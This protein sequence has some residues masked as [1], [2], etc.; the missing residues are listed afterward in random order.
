MRLFLTGGTGFFGRWLLDSLVWANDRAGIGATAVVLTRTPDALAR[1]APHLVHRP[2]LTFHSGDVRDFDFPDGHFSHVL[3]AATEATVTLN[4]NQPLVM[5]ETIITGTRRVLDFAVSAGVRR[6]LLTSSGAVYG[7]Q[8]QDMTHIPETYSGAPDPTDPGVAYGEGKRAAEAMCCM[9]ARQYGIAVSLA[10]CFTFVGP[11]LPLDAHYAV[12]N[13]LRDAAAGGPIHV[14]GDGTTYRSYLYAADLAVWLW[15]LLAVG[16]SARPI[17][18]GSDQALNISELANRIARL[19]SPPTTV[20]FA[21]IAVPGKPI[22][23]YVP[24]INFGRDS[25]GLQVRIGLDDALNRTLRWI[26]DAV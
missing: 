19:V 18:V 26:T 8:P 2:E 3:H 14:R 11:H 12:G 9:Y 1:K 24:S 15:T 16:E 23:R 6:F 13:F 22:N 5:L 17:N 7:R 25:V 21:E 4:V 10:R 20:E